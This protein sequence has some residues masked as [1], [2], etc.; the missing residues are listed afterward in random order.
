MA[1]NDLI[2]KLL[3]EMEP[4]DQHISTKTIIRKYMNTSNEHF[5][6]KFNNS[7]DVKLFQNAK[8]GDII[9]SDHFQVNGCTFFLELTPNGWGQFKGTMLW[10]ALDELPQQYIAIK[11]NVN[12]KC[13]AVG[14]VGE[15]QYLLST[16]L[17]A[18]KIK[19]ASYSATSLN[20][21]VFEAF[22]GLNSFVFE[23]NIQIIAFYD[24]NGNQ[25][26]VVQNNNGVKIMPVKQNGHIVAVHFHDPLDVQLFKKATHGTIIRSDYFTIKEC[27]LCLEIT[28]NGWNTVTGTSMVWC[29]VYK[30]P[31]NV[32][33]IGLNFKYKCDS[34]SFKAEK[35]RELTTQIL[36][37]TNNKEWSTSP[38]KAINHQR[39]ANLNSFIFECEIDIL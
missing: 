33:S 2:K 17:H 26:N 25:Y 29:S 35:M 4:E 18:T 8:R 6:W 13:D 10:C 23:C 27:E 12:Q 7:A 20:G 24:Q 3:T 5:V 22:K 19:G 1:F 14:F 39:L 9:T 36:A 21:M 38:D 16:Q 28:P 37:A 15:G 30:L 32:G 34:V 31:E 11:I